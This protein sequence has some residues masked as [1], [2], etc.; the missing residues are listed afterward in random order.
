MENHRLKPMVEGYNSELFNKLYKETEQL[1]KSLVW[2]IDHRRYGVDR[3]MIM[4]W[5]DDKFIFVFNKHCMDNDKSPDVLK[6]FIITALQQFKNRVLRQA[7]TKKN[8]IYSNSIELE[9]EYN[10]INY[11]IEDT[12]ISNDD[13]FFG[14]VLEYFKSHLTADAFTLL[15]LQLNPP[16]FILN[17][18]KQSNST[19]PTKLILEFFGL[20]NVSKNIKYIRNLRNDIALTIEKAKE[21]I[22]P[23]LAF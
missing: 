2:G 6:G 10:L 1:R 5:F 12:E 22:N 13:M 23:N 14:L 15:Q 18:I 19:I 16:P 3:D 4:S 17:R 8:E 9:G 11:I 20:E 7:Y 21:E